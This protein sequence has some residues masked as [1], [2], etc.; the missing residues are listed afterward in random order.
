MA[1]DKARIGAIMSMVGIIWSWYPDMRFF[2][3]VEYLYHKFGVDKDDMFYIE[4]DAFEQH[5]RDVLKA[6]A[7]N[8]KV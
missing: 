7:I 4:D 3:F 2:Q 5:L 8:G 6:G 1:R